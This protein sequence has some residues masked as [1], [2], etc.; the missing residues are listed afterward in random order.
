MGSG[1]IMDFEV[2]PG[3]HKVAIKKKMVG[4]SEPI[5]IDL[6]SGENKTL[7]VSCFKYGW[8]IG[9]LFFLVLYGIYFVSIGLLELKS[10]FLGEVLAFVFMIS[11]CLFLYY[12]YYYYKIEEMEED[13]EFTEEE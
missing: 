1:K 10:F 6:R 2:S 9:L 5:I 12:R 13:L 4:C 11:L 3:T 7:S 8:L